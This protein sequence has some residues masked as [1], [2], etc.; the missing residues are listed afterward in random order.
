ML[1]STVPDKIVSDIWRIPLDR[2]KSERVKIKNILKNSLKMKNHHPPHIFL[3]DTWYIVTAATL[4]HAP[5]LSDVYAKA[6][7][8]DRLRELMPEFNLA[9]LAWVILDNHYHV[10]FKTQRGNALP[11]FFGR[12]HGSTSRQI[13]RR[14]DTAGRQIWHNYWDACIRTEADLWTRFNY[15]HHNPV[16][17]GYVQNLRDWEFSSYHYYRNLKGEKWLADCWQR[18]PVIDFIEGDDFQMPA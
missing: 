8:R 11:R 16:K 14:D 5:L 13:N 10:I 12:L 3:D 6:L 17:H 15:V 9:L 18:Y 4:N 7:I 1:L 2:V